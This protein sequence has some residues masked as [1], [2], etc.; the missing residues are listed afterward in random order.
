MPNYTSAAKKD[1]RGHEYDSAGIPVE[2]AYPIRLSYCCQKFGHQKLCNSIWTL[3]LPGTEN[4]AH[5][6]LVKSPSR[7]EPHNQPQPTNLFHT[8]S[9][10]AMAQ[11]HKIV[12]G[13]DFGGSSVS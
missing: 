13:I 9:F 2:L 5:P 7:L 12:V 11:L 1:P 4:C 10:T 8:H 6:Q 3:P